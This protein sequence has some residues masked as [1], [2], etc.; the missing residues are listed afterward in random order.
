LAP[1]R[2]AT[3]TFTGS[4]HVGI[5]A[6]DT[7]VECGN[8]KISAMPHPNR[9]CEPREAGRGNLLKASRAATEAIEIASSLRSS[10]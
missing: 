3:L 9:H 10:Q 7:A 5:M 2:N 1:Y 8:L 6:S 4:H